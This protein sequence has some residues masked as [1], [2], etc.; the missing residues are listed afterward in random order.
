VGSEVKRY[1][2]TFASANDKQKIH[3]EEFA[4]EDMVAVA[5]LLIAHNPKRGYEVIHV[6]IDVVDILV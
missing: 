2:V 5:R 6:S 1:L 3:E 4:C